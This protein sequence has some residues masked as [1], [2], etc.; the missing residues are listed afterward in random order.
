MA[1][2][3]KLHRDGPYKVSPQP[4]GVW[5]CGCGLSKNLPYCDGSHS[6]ARSEDKDY[7]YIYDEERSR[8]VSRVRCQPT[9]D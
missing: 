4:R 9:C 2:I 7:I 6:Q 1:R 5:I 3:L 8:V